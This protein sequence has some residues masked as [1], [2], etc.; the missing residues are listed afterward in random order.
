[1]MANPFLSQNQI[2]LLTNKE[3]P[4][5][6]KRKLAAAMI[7]GINSENDRALEREKLNL[8]RSKFRWNTPLVIAITGLITLAGTYVVDRLTLVDQTK[9]DL[10]TSAAAA[11][12]EA[13]A[14]EQEFQFQIV[15]AELANPEKDNSQ[16]AATLLF[17]ARAGVLSSLNSEELKIMAQEQRENL[18]AEIIP[19]LTPLS[20]A[21]DTY[22]TIC[23]GNVSLAQSPLYRSSHIEFPDQK[24]CQISIN[25]RPTS[26]TPDDEIECNGWSVEFYYPPYID[27]IGPGDCRVSVFRQSI[28]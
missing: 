25:D 27:L 21:D 16:K 8:A 15:R 10:Q 7:D 9:R 28:R 6:V 13:S 3:I 26:G 17:L 12:R 19:T 2:E 23:A 4:E 20:E 24:L 5:S 18:E 14:K 11:E 1:M 22:K